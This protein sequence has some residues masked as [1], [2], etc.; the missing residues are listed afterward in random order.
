MH[1]ESD[2]RKKASSLSRRQLI[3]LWRQ[4]VDEDTPGWPPGKAFE[5]LVLRAFEL[6][7]ARILWPF[8]VKLGGHI[9]EQ[10]DGWVDVSGLSC[11][12][13]S[14]QHAKHNDI[15]AIAKLRNQLTRRPASTIGIVFSY[16]GFTIPAL[17]LTQYVA[18][19]TILLWAGEEVSYALKNR[20]M[21]DGLQR[22]FEY[23]TQ[24]GL[25]DYS[26]LAETL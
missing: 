20:K 12:I 5:Y 22:K 9:V 1:L 25:P 17:R 4:I 13:E 8:S 26:L 15:T 24:T 2:Y 23:A 14:K 6:E 18:P 3:S 19:Q 11:I 10:I 16:S 7:R 21:I